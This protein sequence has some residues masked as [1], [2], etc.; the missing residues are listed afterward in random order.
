MK[1]QTILFDLDDTLIH[2][3][4]YFDFVID[5]FVDR[6]LT[7]FSG[8]QL[9]PQHIKKKQVEIDL[10][11]VQ[12]HGFKP[13]RFPKSFVETYHWFSNVLGRETSETEEAHLM[14]LG[15][16]V[17]SYTVEPYPLMHETLDALRSAGHKLYL[18]TG[19]DATIQM[20]KVADSGLHDYFD[21]RVFVTVH[22][23][24][25]Y[26][27]SLVHEQ[28]FDPRRTWMIGNSVRTDVLPALHAG[29]HTIYIP[30]HQ[31]WEYNTGTIDVEPQGAFYQLESLREVPPTIDEYVK[32]TASL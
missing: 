4:R 25:E 6:M 20:K 30:A 22:K 27:K 31:D 17:Y 8:H 28:R 26:M 24:K 1:E 15:H 13:E 12:I 18:Y 19:G 29:I 11:G 2:C 7:W 10:A 9:T 16:T 32:K 21:D 14:D 5:Q 23:T 3:N